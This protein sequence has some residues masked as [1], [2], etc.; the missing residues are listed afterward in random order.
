MRQ[1]FFLHYPTSRKSNGKT[2]FRTNAEDREDAINAMGGA[3]FWANE[4]N[5][6]MYSEPE[7][8]PFF[9]FVF[10]SFVEIYNASSE[11]VTWTDIYCYDKIRNV[12]L[13]QFEVTEILKCVGW[14]SSEISRMRESEGQT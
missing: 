9:L 8:P 5:R 3:V 1:F 13:T 14:A 11:S 2:V 7:V 12:G 10:K 6:E 4:S